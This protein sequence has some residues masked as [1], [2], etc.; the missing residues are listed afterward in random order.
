MVTLSLLRYIKK[1][2]IAGEK[3]FGVD[4]P[5]FAILLVVASITIQN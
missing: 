5:L 3:F 4:F 1:T 2:Y